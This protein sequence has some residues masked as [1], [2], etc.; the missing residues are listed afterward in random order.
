MKLLILYH[1]NSEFSSSVE[2]FA[3]DC[4][5]RTTRDIEL[6]SLDTSEG[7]SLAATYGI[8][9]YPTEMVIREDGQLVKDWQG[10]SLP[11]FDEVMSYLNS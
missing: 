3:N 1:P 11:L 5:N 4:K 6:V 10:S 2:N 9:D 7:S 8:L